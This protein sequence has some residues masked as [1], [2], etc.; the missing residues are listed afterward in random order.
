VVIYRSPVVPCR[1]VPDARSGK[2][3]QIQINKFWRWSLS[4]RRA[5]LLV[6]QRRR[7]VVAEAASRDNVIVKAKLAIIVLGALVLMANG[8]NAQHRNYSHGH[9]RGETPQYQSSGGLYDSL[10]GGHQPYPN[11]DREL[12][13]NRTCC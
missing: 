11:P 3:Q 13:V 12:Y 1:N 4:K 9:A 5:A 7:T 8:A 2:A 6:R 10:S